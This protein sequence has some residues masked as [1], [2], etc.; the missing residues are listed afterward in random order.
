MYDGDD[1]GQPQVRRGEEQAPEDHRRILHR[2]RPLHALQH[3]R[4]GL[5]LRRHRNEQHLG[6]P[7]ALTVRPAGPGP[8]PRPAD[9]AVQGEADRA[10]GAF[11]SG[12]ELIFYGVAAIAIG[13]AIGTVTVPNVVHA[14]LFLILSLMGVAGFYILL[15]REFLALVQVLIYGRARV[16]LAPFALMLTR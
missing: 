15:T 2:L 8:G 6:R 12:T 10:L 4:R 9:G 5:Q 1:D 16:P 3:L 7:R 14:A 11:V 13:G